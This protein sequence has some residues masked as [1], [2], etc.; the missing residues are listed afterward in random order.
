MTTKEQELEQKLREFQKRHG[1]EDTQNGIDSGIAWQ[2]EGS[3]G[4]HAMESL[5]EGA[6]FLPQ[7][8]HR[9]YY[10]NTMPSR[11]DVKPNTMG[12][13]EFSEA[14]WKTYITSLYD[15]RWPD[16]FEDITED[17]A[18]LSIYKDVEELGIPQSVMIGMVDGNL[19]EGDL[20]SLSV[21]DI[22]GLIDIG[23]QMQVNV[24]M[25][26]TALSKIEKKD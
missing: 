16:T 23:E 11:T 21:E 1:Y 19:A 13:L 17:L 2:L 4:R 7:K 9:D 5:R 3:V 6:C 22:K 18:G 24:Q 8:Q 12:T 14:F 26:R 20:D 25:L 15:L 10:G